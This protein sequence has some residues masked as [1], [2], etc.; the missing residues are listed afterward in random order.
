MAYAAD[1]TLFFVDGSTI[2]RLSRNGETRTIAGSPDEAGSVDGPGPLA[3][4]TRPQLLGIDAGGDLIVFE[5]FVALRKISPS[6]NVSTWVSF[7]QPHRLPAV[8]LGSHLATLEDNGSVTMWSSEAPE[9]TRVSPSGRVTQ[10][11]V[12]H[13]GYFR[14][15]SSGPNGVWICD[16][17]PREIGTVGQPP[18]PAVPDMTYEILATGQLMPLGIECS[19]QI[20]NAGA[21]PTPKGVNS[22]FA[23][24]AT[25]HLAWSSNCQLIGSKVGE[26][27]AG[28]IE[29]RGLIDGF[30]ARLMASPA[31]MTPRSEGLWFSDNIAVRAWAPDAGVSTVRI[32]PSYITA[33][34]LSPMHDKLAIGASPS[35]V[36]DLETD[37]VTYLEPVESWSTAVSGFAWTPSADLLVGYATSWLVSADTNQH[38]F[39]YP[40][41]VSSSQ[42]GAAIVA[43]SDQLHRL[44]TDGGATQLFDGEGIGKH[45]ILDIAE[46]TNGNIVFIT[47][48]S[49]RVS[50]L[51]LDLTPTRVDTLVDLE[52]QPS[53]I[54]VTSDGKIW[55]G[56]PHALL[57]LRV[58]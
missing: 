40:S 10:Q 42:Y 47:E 3:R 46:E 32:E 23:A 56:V 26:V 36:V 29:D 18:P 37:T 33:L 12:E 21:Y 41:A 11:H 44:Q 28:P 31:S 39:W 15:L 14:T 52:V 34:S 38:L 20:K 22:A 49:S 51:R 13:T 24:D 43:T 9:L 16:D 45:D 55:L 57:R 17:L 58:P 54:A 50:R 35:F 1:G 53:S 30:D 4:F 19:R 25:G 48:R 2:R 8:M 6:G 27:L 5:P 7:G